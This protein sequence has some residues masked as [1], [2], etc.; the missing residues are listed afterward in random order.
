M[1]KFYKKTKL[2]KL[3]SFLSAAL[4]MI[5]AQNAFAFP[6]GT[7]TID[8][9][10]AASATNYVSFTALANDLKNLTRGDGGA[11]N[12][13][14]GGAGVQATIRV[15]VVT[16]TGPY[17]E[18]FQVNQ[19]LGATAA[20]R[21]IINGNGN[22]I[23]H[24][25]T[26]TNQA[27]IEMYGTDFFTFHN[28]TIS[29]TEQSSNGGKNIWIYNS[30]NFNIIKNCNLR[31]TFNNTNR[32]S[33]YIWMNSSTSS[34][35]FSYADNGN[36][37][38][39]DSCDMSS[40]GGSDWGPVYGVVMFGNTSRSTG[41]CTNRNTVSNCNIQ[42]FSQRGV[43]FNYAGGITIRKNL[44]HNTGSTRSTTV[45]GIQGDYSDFNVDQNR[46]Y[47]LNGNTPTTN[48]QMGV[49][50]F[51]FASSGWVFSRSLYTNNV[52]HLFGTST[53]YGAYFYVYGFYGHSLDIVHNTHTISHPTAT[54]NG[55]VFAM[56]GGYWQ[57]LFD[58]NI[59]N[60]NIGGTSNM[61][62]LMY[63]FN[64]TN[65]NYRNNNWFFGPLSVNQ[66]TKFLGPQYQTNTTIQDAYNVGLPTNNISVAPEFVDISSN[67]IIVP[68]SIP[69]ANKARVTTFTRD[70]NNVTRTSTPDI[71]AEEYVIDLAITAFPLIFPTPTCAG[72]E[73]TVKGTIRNN[74]IYTVNNP[75][76][77]F[78]LNGM[79]QVEYTVPG[80]IAPNA[81]VNFRFPTPTKFSVA[82]P[83]TIRLKLAINDDVPSN[84]E[85][86]INFNITPSPGGSITSKNTSLSSVHAQ[87]VTTGRP[88]LTFPNE[89][90]VYNFTA[91]SRVGYVNSQYGSL[92]RG[93]VSAIKV[94]DMSN[95]NA[96]VSLVGASGSAN[97]QVHFMAAKP[98]ENETFEISTTFTNLATGC[99]TTFKRII[100]VAPKGVIG[101]KLPTVVCEKT[102]ILF[103][104]LSSV[105]SGA[106]EYEWS[107]GDGNT[108]DEAS[109][110]HT[111][112]AFGTYTVNVK[113]KT[114]PYDFVTD[115]TFVLEI[116]EVPQALILNTN[117]CEGV[118]IRLRNG[119]IYGGSGVT[120]Y[121]WDYGDNSAPVN[122][123]NKNDLFK[124]YATQGGY[125][126]K[127]TATADGCTNATQKFVYQFARPV[128]NFTQSAGT[129][130]N[131]QFM[132]KNNSTIAN[133]LF[134]SEWDFNDAGN[135]ATLLD[136]TYNFQ[137]A[138]TKNVVLRVISEFG[139]EATSTV[140]VVVK[141]IPTTNFTYPFACS[142]TATQFTNTTN[143]NGEALASNNSIFWNFGDGFTSTASSPNKNWTSVGPKLVTLTTNLQ[144]G[145]STSITK[146]VNVGVQPEVKFNVEDRCAG[147][148]VPFANLTTFDQ[149]TIKYTWNFGDGNTSAIR[150]PVHS[151]GSGV[152]QTFTVQLKAEVVGGCSDSLS[153]TINI[154]P[155]PATCT[156]DIVG[157]ESAATTS[158]LGF[159][160]V[161]I[162]TG[163]TYT[164]FTGDGN[165]V[166][167]ASPSYRYIAPGK[168]CITMI[169]KDANSGCECSQTK[170]FTMTTDINSA[171]SMNNAVSVYPNPNSGIFT[172]AL[173]GVVSTEMSVLVY[174]TVGALIKTINVN[175]SST[176]IDLSDVASGVYTVKVI[177]ENQIATK[178]VTIN[179]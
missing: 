79:P 32:G 88:D 40:P 130:L 126:V 67:S 7:Y 93:S 1:I 138:G 173:N 154:N 56:Y 171:E 65:S 15:N 155:L 166:S 9:T 140:P 99:D 148:D 132:F 127:L 28:L 136:P 102:E 90:M 106:L 153:K 44:I 172:V 51:S 120:T 37:N 119:T 167:G 26:A 135:K 109:P 83:N 141:Q 64:P 46:I 178:K 81:S 54:N 149:G 16:G 11:A 8:R 60:I 34:S 18:R 66:G 144:N 74:G 104:N 133:G 158:G 128:A 13:A 85:M 161:G 117:A 156:F 42:N 4:F 59:L 86:L 73:D 165:S 41:N 170:C 30:A 20:K 23:Q 121:D 62:Q 116:T 105:S 45:Y 176:T 177:A 25:A 143:L 107:F 175:T 78:R 24:A 49:Y 146:E 29:S 100:L 125:L 137:S 150:A 94:S 98:M 123:N 174:N 92:W 12:Y 157:K 89:K 168:Y 75:R 134:G 72:Y 179:R 91:P 35:P 76:V 47:N 118:N 142:R 27:T 95:A 38:L 71:G 19:I 55:Q 152:S 3:T 131:T 14:I 6:G 57:G 108:S 22:T 5:F 77:A 31:R 17:T 50:F 159:K 101:Y 113:A 111:Y 69:M 124:Q 110:I 139:C 82:G 52:V 43:Y 2:A 39:I 162:T 80:G 53:L 36:D 112:A 10:A 129:C 145:C 115:S 103:E 122:V 21:V 164:W 169:A 70:V 68:N 84:D 87:F 147:S 151:Y 163:V 160:P 33:A 63:D 97:M 61:K 114:N 96:L 48:M 58:N